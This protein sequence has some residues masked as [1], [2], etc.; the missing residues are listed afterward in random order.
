[1]FCSKADISSLR[2]LIYKQILSDF[3]SLKHFFFFLTT[4]FYL[5]FGN[6]SVISNRSFSIAMEK[7]NL[8]M[9]RKDITVWKWCKCKNYFLFDVINPGVIL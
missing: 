3:F 6:M 5:F 9:L 8:K 7:I 2:T 4:F 1:M